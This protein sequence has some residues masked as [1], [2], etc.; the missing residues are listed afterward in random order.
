[1]PHY[2]AIYKWPSGLLNARALGSPCD[3]AV[4]SGVVP[5][6]TAVQLLILPPIYVALLPFALSPVFCTLTSLPILDGR[7]SVNDSILT[8]YP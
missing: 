5:L 2:P 1:M 4:F 8:F 6:D 3:S 7:A